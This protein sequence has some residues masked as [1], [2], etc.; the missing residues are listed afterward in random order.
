MQRDQQLYAN[1]ELG[2]EFS[3]LDYIFMAA[4]SK[5][6]QETNM[7]T[8]RMQLKRDFENEFNYDDFISRLQLIECL[9]NF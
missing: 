2:D 6:E 7:K 5:S 4:K 9:I 1:A 3:S 8:I